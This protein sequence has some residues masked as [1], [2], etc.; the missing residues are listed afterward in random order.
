MDFYGFPSMFTF[1]FTILQELCLLYEEMCRNP[2]F[3]VNL[4]YSVS[5]ARALCSCAFIVER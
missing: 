3:S 5:K 1:T 4:Y 2:S